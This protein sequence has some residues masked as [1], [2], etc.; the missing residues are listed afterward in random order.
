[1]HFDV[2]TKAGHQWAALGISGACLSCWRGDEREALSTKS[3]HKLSPVSWSVLAFWLCHH[4]FC[5]KGSP[6]AVHHRL[7]GGEM[8]DRKPANNI[9]TTSETKWGSQH[10]QNE[11]NVAATPPS[12][13][14]GRGGRAGVGRD[15]APWPGTMSATVFPCRHPLSGQ[16]LPPL[17][18]NLT[19][20]LGLPQSPCCSR[21]QGTSARGRGCRGEDEPRCT[22]AI[23]PLKP[24]RRL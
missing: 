12:L 7:F 2:Q 8:A 13:C 11:V 21:E 3:S 20:V 24:A 19:C 6:S 18:T 16:P 15:T 1:M 10:S 5:P 17:P 4:P 23:L 22:G 9:S 14:S